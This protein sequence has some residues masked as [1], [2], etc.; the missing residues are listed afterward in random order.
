MGVA[1]TA[2]V[3]RGRKEGKKESSRKGNTVSEWDSQEA[4]AGETLG[5]GSLGRLTERQTHF[6]RV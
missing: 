3:K 5:T 6:L 4:P 1:R 2:M